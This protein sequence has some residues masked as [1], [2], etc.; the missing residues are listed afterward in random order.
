MNVGGFI[1]IATE[2]TMKKIT[3][4]RSHQSCCFSVIFFMTV[5]FR[6]SRVIVEL[7]VRT[8]DDRVDIEALIIRTIR[9]PISISGRLESSCGMTW[10]YIMAIV[11]SGLVLETSD[12]SISLAKPPRK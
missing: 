1:A 3:N 10:S 4:A 2:M 12:T 8:S 5:P 7:D 11:P 9:T 6:K